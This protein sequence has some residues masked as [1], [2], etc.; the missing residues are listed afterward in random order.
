[1]NRKPSL[2]HSEKKFRI[3]SY[4]IDRIPDQSKLFIDFQNNSPSIQKYYPTKDHDLTKHAKNV[5]DSYRIDRTLL[6][7]ILGDENQNLGAG[8]ETLANIKR[9]RDKDC[10]AVVSGQQAG[11]FS[12]PI[13][14]IFKA[15]S[16]VRLADDLKKQGLNAVPIFWVASED[17]DFEEA[18]EIFVLD[19]NA[20]LRALSNSVSG[21]EENTPVGFVQLDESIKTTID[22]AF[23]ETP[24]TAF[25]KDITN[26]LSNAYSENETYGSAFAKLIHDLLGKFGLITVSPMNRKVRR[27][28]SPIFVEAVERH[29]EITGALIARDNEL[30]VDGYHSQVLVSEDFFPFFYVDKKKK[31]NALRFDKA[32]N[33]IKSINSEKTFSTEEMLAEAENRPESLSPNALMRPIV[34]D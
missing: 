6:C 19:E 5:L 2:A 14:T 4:S 10:V 25:T 12:G 26:V 7:E 33:V 29:R 11:L 20:E 18:N 9:L 23:S 34:Q 21:L 22:R 13:Y 17:H 30:A 15:L 3:D 28:C 27:L 31:R 16:V 24:V 32:K 8:E 1:M